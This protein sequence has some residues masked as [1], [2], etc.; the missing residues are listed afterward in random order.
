MVFY[1]KFTYFA[2]GEH[3]KPSS[4]ETTNKMGLKKSINFRI[5]L[6]KQIRIVGK[7]SEMKEIPMTL[8]RA[9]Q[10]MLIGLTLLALGFQSTWLVGIS[11]AIITVSLLFG[12][13]ASIAFR[14]ARLVTKKD[15]AKD[16]TESVQLTRFNQ[17]IAAV[18]LGSAFLVLIFTENWTAWLL[19]GMVTGAATAAVF[20]FCIGCFFYFQINRFSY[21]WKKRMQ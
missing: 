12:P 20:G 9:N 17:S 16:E 21:K 13:K 2:N 7:V 6:S 1:R 10:I 8:V 11:F 3:I 5:I 4:R 18:L 14:I 19:V 15:L